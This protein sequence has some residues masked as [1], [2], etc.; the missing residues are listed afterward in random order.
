[1]YKAKFNLQTFPDDGV[2]IADLV[3]VKAMLHGHPNGANTY[4]LEIGDTVIVYCSDIEHPEK[5]LNQNV[6]DFAKDADVLIKD[7]QFTDEELPAH[8]GWGHSSWQQ[9]VSVAEQANVKQLVLYHHSPANND[10]DIAKI[11]G[12]AQ[13]AFPN[14]ISAREGMEL[15]L[16]A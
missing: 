2:Q 15:T 14:T 11:E 10:G 9:C 4:R 16:P 6:I 7:A 5:Q 3:Q 12:Q 8:K 13:A 1:M